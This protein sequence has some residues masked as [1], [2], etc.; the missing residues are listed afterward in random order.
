M[1]ALDPLER[2]PILSLDSLA[3]TPLR[4]EAVGD[5]WFF[6]DDD[7]EGTRNRAGLLFEADASSTDELSMSLE[8]SGFWD[9]SS[10]SRDMSPFELGGRIDAGRWESTWETVGQHS[11]ET[12]WSQQSN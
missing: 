12:R 7:L 9:F 2:L 6:W 8:L 4:P 3:V 10:R 1:L 11:G 5:G